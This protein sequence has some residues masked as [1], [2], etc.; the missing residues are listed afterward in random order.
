MLLSQ[1]RRRGVSTVAPRGALSVRRRNVAVS[2]EVSTAS[3]VKRNPHGI[4]QILA[5]RTED[6][7]LPVVSSSGCWHLLQRL[8]R[9]F[10][11]A[12]N[13]DKP[14]TEIDGN[15]GSLVC[16]GLHRDPLKQLS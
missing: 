2:M 11:Q 5:R 13:G 7:P 8:H 6:P 12:S 15:Y 3:D 9:H 14:A 1:S 10:H 16:E 4:D